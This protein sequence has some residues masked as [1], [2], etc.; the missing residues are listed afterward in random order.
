MIDTHKSKLKPTS[1]KIFVALG[2]VAFL[3]SAWFTVYLSSYGGLEFSPYSFQTRA[4][5]FQ[6]IF[7]LK[8]KTTVEISK[9]C[10]S[11]NV[12]KHLTNSTQNPNA[13]ARWDLVSS[14]VLQGGQ[15]SRGEASVLVVALETY[16]S[17]KM[18]LVW[19]NWSVEH[20]K[21]A[22]I[23]WPAIQKISIHHAYFVIPELLG[24][25]LEIESEVLLMSKITKY[26]LYGAL[27]QSER[28]VEQSKWEEAK[29][30]LQWGVSL[31]QDSDWKESAEGLQLQKLNALVTSNLPQ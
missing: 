21:F 2:I 5:N 27:L 9:P 30:T 4:F 18:D 24:E 23:L 11:T 31:C 14:N 28:L 19:D 7:F 16:D 1:Y 3:G 15:Q 12:L 13:L 25:V 29:S 26:S 6:K 10:K 22:A 20:P 8:G 17:S